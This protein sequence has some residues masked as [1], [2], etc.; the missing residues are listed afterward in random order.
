MKCDFIPESV[1]LEWT[2][3]YQMKSYPLI[4]YASSMAPNDV[5]IWLSGGIAKADTSTDNTKLFVTR[6]IVNIK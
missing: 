6:D 2:Q 5:D 1:H 3:F 4:L